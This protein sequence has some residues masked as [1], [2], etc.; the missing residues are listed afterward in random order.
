MKHI[1]S[2]FRSLDLEISSIFE[3]ISQSKTRNLDIYLVFC[4]SALPGSNV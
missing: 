4:I 3:G 2:K 1:K